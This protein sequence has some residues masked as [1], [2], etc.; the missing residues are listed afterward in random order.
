MTPDAPPPPDYSGIAA[1]SEKSAQYSYELGRDQLNWAKEQYGKDSEVI[2]KVVDAAMARMESQDAV[3]AKDRARYE[4]VFQPLENQLSR[5]AQES[6]SPA[7]LEAAAGAAS[8]GVSQ[9]FELARTAAEDR[10]ESFGMDPSQMRSRALDT[11]V[12]TQ[13]AAARAGAAN[14]ARAQQEAVGRALRSEAINVGR[15]YPGQI[16]QT[17]NTALQSGQQGVGSQLNAT[18]S[19]ASTMGTGMQWQGMGN[20]ALGQWGNTLNTGHSNAM[21]SYNAEAAANPLG[22]ALGL[23][24]GIGLGMA[25]KKFGLFEEGGAVPQP[26]ALPASGSP[27]VTGMYVDPLASPSGGAQTDDVPARLNVG[28]FVVPN[29]VTRWK[30]EEFFQKLIKQS[31]EAK[32]EAPAKPQMRALPPEQPVIGTALPRG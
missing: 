15:G 11:S 8:A 2:G 1:A 24:G 18:A 21:A 6:A 5:E 7:K 20:S 3:A 29:D 13:E 12:R 14:Q 9:Q 25:N 31:R 28:E 27:A 22:Q 4:E 10:L 16:A 23:V 19:G 17:Y 26:H 32:A 30:G